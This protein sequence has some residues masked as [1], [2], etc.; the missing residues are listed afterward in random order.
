MKNIILI[1]LMLLSTPVFADGVNAQAAYGDAATL[2]GMK[3]ILG[4]VLFYI[5]S[6]GL[7]NKPKDTAVKNGRWV[8]STLAMMSFIGYS[9]QYDNQVRNLVESGIAAVVWFAIGF[10]IGYVWFKFKSVKAGAAKSDDA[11][12]SNSNENVYL[13]AS[14]ELSS[15]LRNEGLWAKCYADADGNL[16]I[17]NA[18][19]IKSRAAQLINIRSPIATSKTNI[20]NG[21]NGEIFL[22][23]KFTNLNKIIIAETAVIIITFIAATYFLLPDNKQK[24]IKILDENSITLEIGQMLITPI[25]DSTKFE[26]KYKSA[27]GQLYKVQGPT[28]AP[29]QEV[30]GY[31]ET[32]M[33]KDVR[34]PDGTIV[35]NVPHNI[36]QAELLARY[37]KHTAKVDEKVEN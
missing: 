2:V 32:L 17:A 30:V 1:T 16:D 27:N 3:L 4:A 25:A 28:D 23:A 33:L 24:L 13:L 19:Y 34:M 12:S 5:L 10:V 8:A 7:I 29:Y 9:L 14:K 15:D 31:I 21:E 36:T 20:T 6:F 35:T 11:K 18:R 26:F 22:P 37:K